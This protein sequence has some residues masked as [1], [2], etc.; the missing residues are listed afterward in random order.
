MAAENDS[1]I[2]K[3]PANYY[4]GLEE[5]QDI[6]ENRYQMY[7][8]D[9]ERYIEVSMTFERFHEFGQELYDNALSILTKAVAEF[10]SKPS[11]D[12]YALVQHGQGRMKNIPVYNGF[13]WWARYPFIDPEIS[14]FS[15]QL[16]A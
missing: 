2:F 16:S 5:L 11:A 1:D 9:Y 13:C 14:R 8:Q 10:E 7:F 3:W 4:G 12:L 15:S 6:L